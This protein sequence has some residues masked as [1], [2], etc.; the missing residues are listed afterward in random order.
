VLDVALALF[1]QQGYDKTSLRD[2]AE[3]LGVTKAALYYHF[4]RKEDILLELHL[5]LHALGRQAVDAL[6][7]V[8][9]ARA[10][11]DQ[12]ADLIEQVIEQMQSNRELFLLHQRN[13][14]ALEDL[15]HSAQH[16]A[17]HDD[18]EGQF[19]RIVA[20]PSLPLALRV[21]L[22]CAIGAVAG[23]L[24]HAEDTFAGASVDDVVRIVRQVVRDILPASEAGV[25]ER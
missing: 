25:P 9:T 20:Q 23:A 4:Q 21:R 8:D 7:R 12:W 17:E 16:Q 10:T 5:R 22:A 6:R 11:P 14:G 19:R 2:I 3:E 24:M 1:N 15:A 18:L 13:H